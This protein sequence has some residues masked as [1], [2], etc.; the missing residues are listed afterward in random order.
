MS[1]AAF[2]NRLA[3]EARDVTDKMRDGMV[4]A[5][6]PQGGVQGGAQ[7]VQFQRKFDAKS[8]YDDE[9]NMKMQ[10]MD[11]DG[12][13]PFGQVYYDDKVGKWL[14]KKQA[15]VEAANF[16]AYFNK[17][18]NLNDLASRQWAQQINPEFYQA[19]EQEMTQKAEVILRLKKIQLRGPQDKDDLYMLWLI[20]SGRVQLPQD[21]DKL[22]P[23]YTEQVMPT[24]HNQ[25]SL[26]RGLIRFPKF[27]TDEQREQRATGNKQVGAWGS[28]NAAVNPFGDSKGQDLAPA[29]NVPLVK[30]GVGNPTVASD[31]TKFLR[32]GQ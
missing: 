30:N 5:P 13:T 14:E 9:M 8:R 24:A 12:M 27:L 19:R 3:A 10:L 2:G 31:F 28:E 26:Y 1:A 22:G 11:K 25:Q 21:W 29:R 20:E 16:D 18:F 7:A 6:A 17:N 15:A 4:T 23:G 32:Q